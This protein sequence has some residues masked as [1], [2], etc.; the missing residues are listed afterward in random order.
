LQ[1]ELMSK[2]I[3]SF[4]QNYLKQGNAT[5][6]KAKQSKANKSKEKQGK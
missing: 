1:K 2:L 6:S 4:S 5:Q 3:C